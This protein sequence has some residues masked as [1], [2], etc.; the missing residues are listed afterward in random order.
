MITFLKTV[1][2]ITY[3][4]TNIN[5]VQGLM[6]SRMRTGSGEE[7]EDDEEDRGEAGEAALT[8]G[9]GWARG[10]SPA[11]ASRCCA[12][13]PCGAGGPPSSGRPGR[14]CR[15]RRACSLATTDCKNWCKKHSV[16]DLTWVFAGVGDEVAALAECLPAHDTLVR[17]FSWT[18][19][20][21]TGGARRYSFVKY[22]ECCFI[23]M[24]PVKIYVVLTPSRL[25]F[26]PN[27]SDTLII[28]PTHSLTAFYSSGK[29]LGYEEYWAGTF[30]AAYYLWAWA[31]LCEC[32]CASS[33]QTSGEIVSRSTDRDMAFNKNNLS[34]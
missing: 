2:I 19:T 26:G 10:G 33:C 23:K 9:R 25:I 4:L 18:N 32:K 34:L 3:D 17:L 24:V 29:R 1:L 6:Q 27:L 30:I 28:L 12:G 14:T 31:H 13:S 5:W 8:P 20:E 22:C 21:F 7:G 15:M 16:A 11:S